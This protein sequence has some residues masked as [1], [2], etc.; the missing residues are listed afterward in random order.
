MT[1]GVY[2]QAMPATEVVS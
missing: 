2:H 1:T